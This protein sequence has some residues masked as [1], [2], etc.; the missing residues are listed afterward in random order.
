MV[1]A[2]IKQI[3]AKNSLIRVK[4]KISLVLKGFFTKIRT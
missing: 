4:I 3:S 2:Q 1:S